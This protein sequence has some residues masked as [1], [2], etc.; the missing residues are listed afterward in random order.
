[1]P[2][3]LIIK[4]FLTNHNPIGKDEELDIWSEGTEHQA[5]C[6]HYATEDG[7]RT[8]PKVVHTGAADRTW[9]KRGSKTDRERERRQKQ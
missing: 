3:K 9:V 4:C 2:L 7:H 1:M 8:S 6:H 5:A